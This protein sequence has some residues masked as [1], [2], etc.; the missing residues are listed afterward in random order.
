MA[1]LND[2]LKDIAK[3]KSLTE[4]QRKDKQE[5]I[6]AQIQLLQAQIQQLQKQ[7]KEKAE[8]KQEKQEVTAVKADGINRPT[9]SNQLDVYV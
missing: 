6:N 9:D 7:E 1:S 5:T 8:Q 4:K 2:E 3:D